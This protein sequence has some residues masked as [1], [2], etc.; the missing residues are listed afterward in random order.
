MT[1]RHDNIIILG[2]GG[3][4]RVLIDLIITSG[5]FAITGILDNRVNPGTEQFGIPVLGSDDLLDTLFREE[6]I[7]NA[8]IGVGSIRVGRHRKDLFERLKSELQPR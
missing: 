8:C 5:R 2:A 6:G 3:H 4:A 1:D 7:H